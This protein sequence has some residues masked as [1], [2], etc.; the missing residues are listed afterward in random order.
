M[1]TLLFRAVVYQ[2]NGVATAYLQES[3]RRCLSPAFQQPR[4]SRLLRQSVR[5][6]GKARYRSSVLRMPY[7]AM[8]NG[9]EPSVLADAV[10]GAA[11]AADSTAAAAGLQIRW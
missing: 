8:G 2:T 5:R 6:T 9:V 11:T 1:Q 3:D 10:A 7:V 4:R